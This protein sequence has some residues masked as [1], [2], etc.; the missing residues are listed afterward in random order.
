MK[1]S[2]YNIRTENPE[3]G[4]TILFNTLYG[5]S[6]VVPDT[7]ALSVTDLLQ[8]DGQSFGCD[9]ETLLFLERGKFVVDD[10]VDE[11]EIVRNRKQCGMRDKN[12]VD[13]IIMPNLYCNFACPYCYETHD[14]SRRMSPETER[15]VK[16]WLHD[17]FEQ[18]KVVLLNWFGGEPLL[19]PKTILSIGRFAKKRSEELGVSLVSNVTTNGYTFTKPL[20]AELVDIGILSYQITVDGP[21][22][23]HD[24]TR[25]LKSGRGS[26]SR[27]FANIL[28]LA[29]ASSL[30]KIS[31]RVNYNHKNIYHIPELLSMFPK[32]IRPQLRIVFEPIFGDSEL[33]AT[34]NLSSMEISRVISDYYLMADSMGYDVV[35]GGLGVGRLVYCYAEREH[36]Y[37]VNYN[38]DIFKCTVSNFSSSDRVGFINEKG[39]LIR[40]EDE[41]R[42]WFGMGL[43]EEKCEACAFLPLCMGGCRK[44]RREN[45]STGSY[46]HLV[47]TNTSQ[48]LKSVSFGSFSELLSRETENSRK[49]ANLEKPIG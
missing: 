22:S 12:R 34:E 20:I 18:H 16:L 11:L 29:A 26:F 47:P 6:A 39:E 10:N 33:S 37:I 1:P 42:S 48:V 15:S 25:I 43:F 38:A 3:T 8:G 31:L 27:V 4:E 44:D 28:S 19:S 23:V 30:L 24:K 13:V 45:R 40:D 17:L 32:G 41:C 35:H 46:C 49:C 9:S 5:S 36:Q 2:I 7:L 14:S 21:P